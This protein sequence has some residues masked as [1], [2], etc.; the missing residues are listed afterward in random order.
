VYKADQTSVIVGANSRRELEADTAALLAGTGPC[1]NCVAVPRAMGV[2]PYQAVMVNGGEVRV[3]L[4]ATLE[5]V[6]A[7]AGRRPADVMA[8]LQVSKRFAGK[9]IPIEFARTK[10]DVL[11]LVMEGNEEIRW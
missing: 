1:A 5:R 10:P 4:G 6:I 8:T 9:M 7:A 3:A 2:N 11:G